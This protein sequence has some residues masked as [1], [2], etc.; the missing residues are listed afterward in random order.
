MLPN[1][2]KCYK[3]NVFSI[4]SFL[5]FFGQKTAKTDQKW[6][7]LA[8]FKSFDKIFWNMVYKCFPTKENLTNKMF[9]DFCIFWQKT[10]KIDQKWR[11]LAK[12]KPFDKIFWNLVCRFFSANKNSLQSQILVFF[13]QNHLKL[14]R[15]EENCNNPNS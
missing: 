10:A 2:R 3:K 15:N 12:S 11:K 6:R 1:K 7:N 4:L 14:T 5:V 9:F 13:C 8:K